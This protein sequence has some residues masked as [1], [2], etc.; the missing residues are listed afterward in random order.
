V[1]TSFYFVAQS[2][3]LGVPLVRLTPNCSQHDLQLYTPPTLHDPRSVL[4]LITIRMFFPPPPPQLPKLLAPSQPQASGLMVVETPLHSHVQYKLCS[5]P[6]PPDTDTD[7]VMEDATPPNNKTTQPTKPMMMQ[8]NTTTSHGDR[9]SLHVHRLFEPSSTIPTPGNLGFMRAT[10]APDTGQ[11]ADVLMVGEHVLVPGAVVSVRIVGYLETLT[12]DH[13]V[14]TI[15]V[16][17]P[18]ESASFG[19]SRTYDQY[20]DI[21]DLPRPLLEIVHRY[22]MQQMHLDPSHCAAVGQFFGVRAA[23]VRLTEFR[24]AWKTNR[25]H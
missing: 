5:G 9:G 24:V 6:N 19:T 7:T 13:R 18:G 4:H 20:R 12:P 17:V 15:F 21:Q 2:F 16:A 10:S 14:H 22:H 1:S 3:G 23:S 25:A 11:E 8:P